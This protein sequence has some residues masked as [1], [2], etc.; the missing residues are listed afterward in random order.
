MPGDLPCGIHCVSTWTRKDTHV[1]IASILQIVVTELPF[2]SA[3]KESPPDDL[4]F[5]FLVCQST[6]TLFL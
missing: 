1:G 2:G 4:P 5:S 6:E 3:A